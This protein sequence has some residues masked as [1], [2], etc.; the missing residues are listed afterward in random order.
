MLKNLCTFF[1]ALLL[2]AWIGQNPGPSVTG[3]LSSASG[4]GSPALVQAVNYDCPNTSTNCAI[5]SSDGWATAGTGHM[6]MVLCYSPG[7][8]CTTAPVSSPSATWTQFTIYSSNNTASAYYTCSSAAFTSITLGPWKQ[9]DV[10]V[11]YSGLATS[12]CLDKVTTYTTIYSGGTW[13]TNA[14]GTLSS[15]NE[16]VF[17]IVNAAYSSNPSITCTSPAGISA[18]ISVTSSTNSYY[19]TLC[20]LP[21]TSTSGVTISGTVVSASLASPMA[22]LFSFKE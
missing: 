1:V 9:Q 3:A 4:G 22:T 19:S 20:A 15:A 8:N 7:S 13:A 11:E 17:A 10:V 6:V 14:S 18:A 5:N 16:L 2:S 21:V 12:S